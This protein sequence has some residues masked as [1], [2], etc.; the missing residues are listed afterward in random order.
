MNEQINAIKEFESFL[1]PLRLVYSKTFE[2]ELGL[3]ET[4]ETNSDKTNFNLR[5]YL[6]RQ[7]LLLHGYEGKKLKYIP[8]VGS[9]TIISV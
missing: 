4:G 1:M 7:R 3:S 2:S 5:T 9:I 8:K 6:Q